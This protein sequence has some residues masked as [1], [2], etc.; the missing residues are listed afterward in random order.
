MYFPVCLLFC[1]ETGSTTCKTNV[2]ADPWRTITTSCYLISV[3]QSD[4]LKESTKEWIFEVVACRRPDTH[5][6]AHLRGKREDA[7]R[8]RSRLFAGCNSVRG[9]WQRRCM[10]TAAPHVTQWAAEAGGPC[11]LPV[12]RGQQNATLPLQMSSCP[13]ERKVRYRRAPL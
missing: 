5:L 11:E 9:A 10:T 6:T 3:T 2:H 4:L 1:A 12:I 13:A 7:V 8:R